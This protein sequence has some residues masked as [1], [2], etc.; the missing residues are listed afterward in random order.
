MYRSSAFWKTKLESTQIPSGF[1]FGDRKGFTD[2]SSWK[3]DP[4]TYGDISPLVSLVKRDPRRPITLKP[5]FERP[6]NK[7]TTPGPKYD[8]AAKPGANMPVWSFNGRPRA[9]MDITPGPGQYETRRKP[10]RNYPIAHGTLY[11][12]VLQ[13]RT[14]PPEPLVKIPGPG[15]YKPPCFT[16]KYN[17]APIPPAR[18]KETRRASLADLTMDVLDDDKVLEKRVGASTILLAELGEEQP[19][20]ASAPEL[21]GQVP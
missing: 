6:E 7:S 9:N 4:G 16:D 10:G 13:G 12:I 20:S 3:L 5:R 18:K 21:P 17:V 14:K 8:V 15:Q 2:S 19:L 1:G 11:D